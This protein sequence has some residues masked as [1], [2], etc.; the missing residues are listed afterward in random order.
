MELFK[1]NG[2]DV[3]LCDD[4]V[5]VVDGYWDEVCRGGDGWEGR[6]SMEWVEPKFK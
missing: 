3:K 4:F 1:K 2:R 6:V 5:V